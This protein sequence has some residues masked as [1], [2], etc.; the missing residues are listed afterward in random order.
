[1]ERWLC[2]LFCMSMSIMAIGQSSRYDRDDRYA[3]FSFR[4]QTLQANSNNIH[5]AFRNI[6][7]KDVLQL[8][9]S[10][11]SFR[12]NLVSID[13]GEY[14]EDTFLDLSKRKNWL[15]HFYRK[16]GQ[17]FSLEKESFSVAVNPIVNAKLGLERDND[18]L[19]FQNTRGFELR[20]IVDDKVYFYSS[21]FE[22]QSR[23]PSYIDRAARKA[24][25]IPG[26][27][28]YKAYTSTFS[29]NIKGFDYLNAVAY[30]GLPV[31]KHINLELGHGNHFIGH[32][33]HSLLLS[34]FAHNY[35]YLSL[36]TRVWK[37]HYKNIFAELTPLSTRL[38]PTGLVPKKYM[39]AHYL[40]YKPA[41]NI[42]LGLFE[43][44]IF[45]REDHF[46]FQYLNPIIL[47]RTVE[48]FLDS[49][50]NVMIGLNARW[51]LW[52]SFSVYGQ[53]MIDE[54][55]IDEFLSSDQWWGNKYGL[56]FGLFYPNVAGVSNLDI[57]I[58][59]NRVRPYMYSHHIP[60]SEL[61]SQTTASYSHHGQAMAHPLG[62]NFSEYILVA[63]YYLKEKW[64]S[65]FIV[66][67]AQR[68]VNT[69][70]I[71]YGS[72]ILISNDTRLS[73][74]GI[75]HL[76]GIA[77]RI[78][79]SSLDISYEWAHNMYIDL[80]VATHD[81]IREMS[82]TNSLY[83]GGGVRMNVSNYRIEY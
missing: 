76:Q 44:V 83:F 78:F 64:S 11:T 81:I 34:D 53:W 10:D 4:Q 5:L 61:A 60:L 59:Y 71:N 74:Y 47:Y 40:S 16:K 73:D 2:L 57:R 45:G 75:D 62:A 21:L 69:S 50:D 42:E 30:I 23:F 29:E 7:R 9:G 58:E 1:M 27:G 18:F 33:Y 13:N 19:I 32:G 3:M 38:S 77:E 48:Q 49:P 54:F 24:Q 55:K 51:D 66:S 80:R 68:G 41:K 12:A 65:R 22:N 70:N 72:D 15:R 17:F 79:H 67:S 56:Q 39:A 14:I 8:F 31:S 25:S 20:A 82:T 63:D 28:F 43:T 6:A 52:S 46:E 35:F 37:F 36:D 26:Q